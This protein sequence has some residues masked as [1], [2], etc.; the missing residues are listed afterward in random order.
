MKTKVI[1]TSIVAALAITAAT[2][3]AATVTWDGSQG[4]S[5][6]S[7]DLNW[8][9]DTTPDTKPAAGD[10]VIISN[11]NSVL[12]DIGNWPSGIDITLSGGSDL[13]Q[14]GGALRFS[15]STLKVGSG[16][17]LSGGFWDLANGTLEFDDGASATMG[18]WE[19]KGT[20][21]FRF[22]LGASGF[23]TLNPGT[24]RNDGNN[25]SITLAQKMALATY[26]ADLANYTG[27][28]ELLTL[29][30]YS[31]DATG[32]DDATFQNATLNT[33]NVPAGLAAAF[34]W[35]ATDKSIELDITPEPATLALSVLGLLGLLRRRRRA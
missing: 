7:D 22:N 19:N 10:T 1:L 30:D 29:V 35:N 23:T 34:Q 3:Q 6:W 17:T 32:L 18:N 15:G 33:L 4:N 21:T 8:T 25:H 16:S 9:N 20:N 31:S 27:G 24:F 13:A 14:S 11:G 26:E 28:A 2:S 12:S 5:L